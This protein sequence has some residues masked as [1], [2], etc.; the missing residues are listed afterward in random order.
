MPAHVSVNNSGLSTAPSFSV[1]DELAKLRD[2]RDQG[3]LTQAE[4][5]HQKQLL[6]R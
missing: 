5:D 2:L 6:I 3:V 4:F 1:A